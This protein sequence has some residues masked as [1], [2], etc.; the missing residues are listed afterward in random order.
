MDD[1]HRKQSRAESMAVFKRR[2]ILS[3]ARRVFDSEGADGLNMRTIAKEAGYSLGAAYS[4]F[5]TKEE[6]E[7]E[8]LAGILGDL[9][10]YIKATLS[11]GS[12][13][14]GIHAFSIFSAYF[15]ERPKVRKLLLLSL[16]GLGEKSADIPAPTRKELNSRLLTLMG[17][18][19]NELHQQTPA[20]ATRAQEETTDFVAYL[21]GLMLLE[22]GDRLQLLNQDNQEMVDRYGERMLLRVTQ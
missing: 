19:A 11:Q 15:R 2:H 18:L 3:A 8:L 5:R 13:N 4:Y 17:L 12:G 6:I 7:A 20:S 22:N 1:A 16:S 10:R 21:L 14:S 9:A